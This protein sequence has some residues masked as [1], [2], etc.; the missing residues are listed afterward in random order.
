M[1][2]KNMKQRFIF[3]CAVFL[4]TTQMWGQNG[5]N[6]PSDGLVAYYPF[7]GNA[8]DE[9]GNGNHGTAGG[10]ATLT[11]DRFGNPNSAYYFGGVDNSSYIYVPSSN[12]LNF[13]SNATYSFYVKLNSERGMDGWGSPVA[14]GNQCIFAKDHDMTGYAGMI[15]SSESGS[16]IWIAS[17]N[18]VQGDIQNSLK[19]L[20]DGEWIHVV[21]VFE[22]NISKIYVDGQM[23]SQT[24]Y[25][26]S[27][28]VGNDRDLYFGRF[29]NYW[30]PLDGVLDDIR[31]YN[32][33]LTE[34]EVK[35][36]YNGSN[37]N[38]PSQDSA[39]YL[40]LQ[41]TDGQMLEIL[42]TNS[43]ILLQDDKITVN[44]PSAQYQFG[45]DEVDN[46]SF[47]LKN[48][49][50]TQIENVVPPATIK[51]FLDGYGLLHVSGNQPLGNIAI[52]N[53]AGHLMK[54]IKTSATEITINISGFAKG[55]YLVKTNEK[56]VKIIKK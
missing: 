50:V 43:E 46:F 13:N 25:S 37:D 41:K 15:S 34:S 21:F 55:I 2:I 56:T 22:G 32:R 47:L 24:E 40:Y 30:Y 20:N 8:N 27:I 49:T 45:Y 12:S 9:S 54:K 29:S 53:T 35:A 52:Y 4:F 33:A 23:L 42:F 44:T 19:R 11:E 10:G 5:N 3:L 28:N 14:A 51:V 1:K 48:V 36:L 18:N 6:I 38:Q 31:I 16:N 17:F 7:N 26:G 39:P